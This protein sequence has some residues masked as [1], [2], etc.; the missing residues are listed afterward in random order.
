MRILY[1]F[2]GKKGAHLDSI[3][4]GE[5][6]DDHLYGMMRLRRLGI[7]TDYIEPEQIYSATA[8]RL[9]R[10]MC[11]VYFQHLALFWKFFSY[12]VVFAPNA[13]GSELFFSLFGRPKWVVY[14]FSIS[15]LIGN[16]RMFRQKVFYWMIGRSSGI[17]T[18]SL[19]EELLLKKMFPELSSKIFFIP[20]GTDTSF[21][22]PD[23]TVPEERQ[24]FVPGFDPCRDYKTLVSA[25]GDN[26]VKIVMTKSTTS[27]NFET[28]SPNIEL[29]TMNWKEL[30]HEYLKSQIVV[31]TLD[32]KNGI[33]EASGCSTL[34]QAMAMGKAIIVTSTPTTESYIED[35][36]NGILVPMH[37]IVALRSAIEKLLADKEL[38]NSLGRQA[39]IFAQRHCS[40]DQTS[41]KLA[42]FFKGI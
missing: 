24:I 5:M 7:E 42:L 2:N 21:F 25:I 33:N 28:A 40:S 15:G 9:I 23:S 36:R 29:K 41:K 38:R 19:Y 20:F 11:T 8:S 27:L 3:L 13:Y 32:I 39:R 6:P 1:L 12:D 30:A 22:K 37:D 34:V 18:L 16:R 35:G 17:I 14:D 4:K 26:P 10:K 31:I